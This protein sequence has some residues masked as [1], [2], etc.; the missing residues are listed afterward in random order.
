[1]MAKTPALADKNL[2]INDL[3]KIPPLDLTWKMLVG[4]VMIPVVMI[5]E[6]PTFAVMVSLLNDQ[7]NGWIL[8]LYSVSLVEYLEVIGIMLFYRII[9]H[10][11]PMPE[12]KPIN[13]KFNF[14]IKRKRVLL[15][16]AFVAIFSIAYQAGTINQISHQ[17][18]KTYVDQFKNSVK[19]IDSIGIFLHNTEIALPMFIPV[20][21]MIWGSFAGV[22]TGFAYKAVITLVPGIASKIPALALLYLSPFGIMELVAYSIGMSRSLILVNAI[23]TKQYRQEIRPT[24][25]EIGL[26]VSLLLIAGFIEFSMISSGQFKAGHG[27]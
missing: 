24:I 14:K 19:G 4:L 9:L 12:Q 7:L 10:N 16:L 11:A 8:N 2:M 26:V 17:D 22:S 15:V 5:K 20:F 1:M 27:G 13:L 21:G 3:K 18:A 25:I 6:F 23:R